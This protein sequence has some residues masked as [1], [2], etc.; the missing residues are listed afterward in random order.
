MT[1]CGVPQI[2]AI[3]ESVKGAR[4]F[5]VPVI[6]DGGIRN[7]GDIVKALAV[8]ASTVMLG[9]RLAGTDESPGQVIVKDGKKVKIVRGMAGYGANMSDRQ[10]RQEK[11]HSCCFLKLH[12]Y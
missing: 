9:S 10:R 6:A 1:G 3:I 7:S 4:P 12:Y 2:T 5:D 8:G 11:V